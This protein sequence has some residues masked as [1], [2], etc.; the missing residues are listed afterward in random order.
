MRDEEEARRADQAAVMEGRRRRIMELIEQLETDIAALPRTPENE[1][2]LR[3]LT[4][5]AQE[6]R[7]ILNGPIPQAGN[8]TR[9]AKYAALGTAAG[10][11]IAVTGGVALLGVLGF[12]AG[13]VG[14][15]TIAA[16]VQSTFYGAW[17]T[18]LFSLCQSAAATGV[19][20][21]TGM[22][23]GASAGAVAGTV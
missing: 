22:A 17:T 9:Y 5:F 6:Q 7:R 11:A 14:A 19:I 1:D 3:R 23:T 4:D 12:G 8:W 18:G 13:G 20:G 10:G 21:A 15:G 2:E 16:G